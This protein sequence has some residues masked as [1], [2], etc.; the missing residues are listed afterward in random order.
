MYL[1]TR[2]SG[3]THGSGHRREYDA[4]FAAVTGSG[5][6]QP[7]V[8]QEKKTKDR[9]QSTEIEKETTGTILEN[10]NNRNALLIH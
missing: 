2:A 3:E 4:P 8:S 9:N 7:T 10:G 5:W 1:F 6:L